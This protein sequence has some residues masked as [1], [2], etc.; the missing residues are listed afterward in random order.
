LERSA[1]CGLK[2]AYRT[3]CPTRRDI[4]WGSNSTTWKPFPSSHVN[5]PEHR[6]GDQLAFP[7]DSILILSDQIFPDGEPEI[8][9]A[10]GDTN[11]KPP[12]DIQA[13]IESLTKQYR[14][15]AQFARASELLVSLASLLRLR[16]LNDRFDRKIHFLAAQINRELSQS[17][18][19]SGCQPPLAREWMRLVQYGRELGFELEISDEATAVLL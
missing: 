14:G 9:A 17:F 8:Q 11:W 10:M 6:I 4:S 15:E 18:C 2:C 19:D 16:V 13:S 7:D 5:P 1:T 3:D 12:N